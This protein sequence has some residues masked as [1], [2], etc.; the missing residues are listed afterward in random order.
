MKPDCRY[1]EHA[2]VKYIFKEPMTVADILKNESNSRGPLRPE[3]FRPTSAQVTTVEI[4]CEEGYW[5]NMFGGDITFD[6]M[7]AL[8]GSY[9]QTAAAGCKDFEEMD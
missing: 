5:K 4:F 7:G 3:H 1:C 6:H 2:R 8:D 9:I